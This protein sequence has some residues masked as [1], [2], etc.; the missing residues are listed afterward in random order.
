MVWS[1]FLVLVLACAT[2]TGAA[3]ERLIPPAVT[4]CPSTGDACAVAEAANASGLLINPCLNMPGNSGH[5]EN[6]EREQA[7]LAFQPEQKLQ[8]RPSGAV[9]AC[10]A[11]TD[12]RICADFLTQVARTSPAPVDATWE[13][14]TS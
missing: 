4:S 7:Y 5:E 3:E 10:G 6:C 1:G 11:S 8:A 2:L 9:E 13:A 14:G 12:Q